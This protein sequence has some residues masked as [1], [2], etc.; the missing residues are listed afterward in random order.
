MMKEVLLEGL[1]KQVEEATIQSW[2]YEEGDSVSEGDELVEVT[3]SEGSV[4]ISANASGVLAEVYFDEGETVPRGE[5]LCLIDDESSDDEDE[6][7]EESDEDKDE[8]EEKEKS[9]DDDE[10]D[11]EDLD[12]DE[13]DFEDEEEEDEE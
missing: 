13:D 6:E 10:E 3:T 8:D 4:M 11:D 9:E 5:V 7:K 1:A 2:F 12:E